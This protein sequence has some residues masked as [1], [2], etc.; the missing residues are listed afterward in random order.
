MLKK[1]SVLSIYTRTVLIAA[2]VLIGYGYLCRN[3]R[4]WFFWESLPV[5]WELLLVGIILVLLN[6]IRIRKQ[7]GPRGFMDVEVLAEKQAG[8]KNWK[9]VDPKLLQ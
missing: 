6:A 2:V 7:Q 5:G 8:N 3:M 9:V 4:I 1:W